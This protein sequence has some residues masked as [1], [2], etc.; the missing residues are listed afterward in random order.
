VIG[1]D[2]YFLNKTDI[3][4]YRRTRNGL[5]ETVI[6][7][8]SMCWG[9]FGNHSFASGQCWGVLCQCC[10]GTGW[11]GADI[12][13]CA[14]H[15]LSSKLPTCLNTA[16]P[17]TTLLHFLTTDAYWA[18]RKHEINTISPALVRGNTAK[19]EIVTIHNRYM[20]LERV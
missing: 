2:A 14:G 15:P 3:T 17:Q 6:S 7:S 12:E 11:E 4:W 9:C 5:W 10:G 13:V 1:D 18:L 20:A 16:M 8:V 19:I